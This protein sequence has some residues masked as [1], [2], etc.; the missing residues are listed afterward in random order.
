MKLNCDILLSTFAFTF[1]LRRY[2]E[3][4]ASLCQCGKVFEKYPFPVGP[5]RCC[6]PRQRMPLEGS[7]CVSMTWR[8]IFGRPWLQACVEQQHRAK[9]I[10]GKKRFFACTNC[11]TRVETLNKPYPKCCRKC[12]CEDFDKVRS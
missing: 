11:R 7:R 6:S 12:R 1:N 3:V 8:V 5:G 10:K 4:S 2:I 9:S